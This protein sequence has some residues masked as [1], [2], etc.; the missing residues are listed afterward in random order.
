MLHFAQVEVLVL[1][2]AGFVTFGSHFKIE[3]VIGQGL[4]AKQTRMGNGHDGGAGGWAFHACLGS[5]PAFPSID[6]LV[7]SSS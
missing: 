6:V 3:I 7:A 4:R 2:G 1:S 5:S